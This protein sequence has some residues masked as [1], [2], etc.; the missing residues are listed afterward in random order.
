MLTSIILS[1]Y[2]KLIKI[3]KVKTKSLGLIPDPT[4]LTFNLKS[5]AI[6]NI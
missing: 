6:F 5:L 1:K 3:S 4:T 2:F